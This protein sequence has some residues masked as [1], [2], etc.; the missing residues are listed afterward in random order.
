[1][2]EK[3]EILKTLSEIVRKSQLKNLGIISSAMLSMSGSK[4]MLNIS[5][6]TKE[7]LSY[8][9]IQRFFSDKISWIDLCLKLFLVNIFTGQ[10]LV[11]AVDETIVTKSGKATHGI[12]LFFN[13]IYQKVMKSL[14]F[15]CISI[16]D[17]DKLKSYPLFVSQLVFTPEEKLEAKAKKEKIKQSKGNKRGRKKGSKNNVKE[18]KLS[19]SFRLLKEQLEKCVSVLKGKLSISHIV[20]DGFY[21]NITVIEIC[22]SLGL[23]LISKLQSNPAIY[24]KY[25]KAY[26]G[27]GRKRIYGDKVDIKNLPY[28]YL[29]SHDIKDNVVTVIYQ[30]TCLHKQFKKEINTV[31]IIKENIKTNKVAKAFF[32]STDLTLSSEQIIQYYSSRFQIEFNFRDAKEFFGLEDFMNTT[33]TTVNNAVNLSF[34]MVLF[35]QILL[36][37]F[38]DKNFN[39]S[40]SI[41]DLIS[42]K[43]AEKY[44]FE[45]FKLFSNSHPNILLP[46]SFDSITSLGRINL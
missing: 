5:R 29:V 1:M 7:E 16:I 3:L 36:K 23:F 32:F 27:R 17:V 44:L 34:F 42:T 28:E 12:D 11:L 45:T 2:T 22:N 21:G 31:I 26:S 25:D 35:S 43:R 41:R 9:S 13:S 4:T 15:S 6:W 18:K 30:L 39:Q 24:Y 20:A 19:G 46:T 38:R 8:R 37:I 33:E 14:C 40:L 10:K